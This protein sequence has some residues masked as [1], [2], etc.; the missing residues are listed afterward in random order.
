MNYETKILL[1]HLIDAINDK[2][3]DWWILGLTSIN[4]IASVIFS[5]MLYLLTKRIGLQQNRTLRDEIKL[6]M[7]DKR[8][9]VYY[10]I[11]E[12]KTLLERGDHYLNAFY[13]PNYLNDIGPKL[14]T[15]HE[16]L[17]DA[18]F[19]SQSL[20]EPEIFEKMSNIVICFTKVRSSYYELNIE[21][22][23]Y[24]EGLT[25]QE[26]NDIRKV[27]AENATNITNLEKEIYKKFPDLIKKIKP[28]MDAVAEFNECIKNSH[29]MEDFD[30][31]LRLGNLDE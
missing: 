7:F 9:A 14:K 31:Y 25:E 27:V 1:N 21:G 29:I 12:A 4:I 13:E 10:S 2:T 30:K 18:M 3:V 8:Y 16:S 22:Y 26:L 20:F 23:R 17:N 24:R 5:T 19:V 28:W 11:I 15:I 6:A